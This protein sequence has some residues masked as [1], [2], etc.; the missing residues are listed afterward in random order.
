MNILCGDILQQGLLDFELLPRMLSNTSTS[1]DSLYVLRVCRRFCIERSVFL[2]LGRRDW[3]GALDEPFRKHSFWFNNVWP[4]LWHV[5]ILYHFHCPSKLLP[6]IFWT[7]IRCFGNPL[8][9]ISNPPPHPLTP[10]PTHSKSPPH[11]LICLE[12]KNKKKENYEDLKKKGEKLTNYNNYRSTGKTRKLTHIW[13]TNAC[14]I[15]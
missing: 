9:P 14:S 7:K 13:K 8:T 2:Q 6:V 1:I 11:T 4:A 12:K 3:L 5:F 15:F 10:I